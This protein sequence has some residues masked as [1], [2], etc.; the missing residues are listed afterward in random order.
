MSS[1]T[2]A[3]LAEVRPEELQTVEGG[4]LGFIPFLPNCGRRRLPFLHFGRFTERRFIR[5][6]PFVRRFCVTRVGL[7]F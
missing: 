3:T 5:F 2:T 7:H 1:T 6:G 4:H